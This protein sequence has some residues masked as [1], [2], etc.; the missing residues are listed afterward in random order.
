MKAT[1]LFFGDDDAEQL[2][3]KSF[4]CDHEIQQQHFGSDFRQVMRISQ[5]GRYVESK[6]GIVFDNILAETN[7]VG[8]TCIYTSLFTVI[9]SKYIKK[10]DTDTGIIT[11]VKRNLEHS[12]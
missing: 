4:W 8:S 6:I 1:S 11:A 10:T 3:L 5:L 9:G 2:V 12:P 7:H